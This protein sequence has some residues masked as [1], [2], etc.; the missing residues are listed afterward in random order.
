MESLKGKKLLTLGATQMEIE[1]IEAARKAGV[2]TIV[3]DNHVDWSEAP[4]KLVADEAWNIS[5]S[6]IKSLK[7]KCLECGV[8]GCMAGFSEKRIYFAL[9]L[10]KELGKPF[11]AD[12]ANLDV[13]ID[14]A[15]FKEMCRKSGITVPKAYKYGDCIEYPVIVKPADN[16]GSRGISICRNDIELSAAYKKALDASDA[17]EVIIEQYIVADETMVYFTVHN[18]IADVSAMCD[19]YMHYFGNDITQLPIGYYYPSKHLDSFLTYNYDKFKTLIR[20]LGIRN[21]LIAF[22]SFAYGDELIP[23]DPTYR[24]DGTMTYHICENMNNCN[25]LDML[26]RYSLTGSMGNDGYISEK[27]NPSFNKIGFQLPVLVKGGTISKIIGLDKIKA[28]SD[29]IFLIQLHF[30]GETMSKSADFSQIL[31]RIHLVSDNVENIRKSI[32]QI[33]NTLK[34][35]DENENDMIICRIDTNKI[36]L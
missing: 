35:E 34:V 10:S 4:A 2:Y 29:V 17:K 24:L 21:G 12:H 11:Y 6:D 5:W 26:I 8:D 16:G 9:K 32:K 27:E 15:K 7:D 19:R 31:C 36:G 22:Q 33:Y 30:E 20:N 25:V 23:F 13:I 28:M 18:G 1:I 3:T 14:K